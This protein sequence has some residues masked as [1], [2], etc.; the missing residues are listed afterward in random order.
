MTSSGV[1]LA[2]FRLVTAP[3]PLCYRVASERTDAVDLC[4]IVPFEAGC[5]TPTVAL[6]VLGDERGAQHGPPCHWEAITRET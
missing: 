2:T 6:L 1:E 4:P 3:Q 5:C